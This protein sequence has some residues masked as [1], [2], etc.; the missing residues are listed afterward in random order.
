[1]MASNISWKD[2]TFSQVLTSINKNKN[3]TII[4]RRNMH[5]A[6]PLKIYRKEI[7]ILTVPSK[8]SRLNVSISSI[9]TPNG[10][11]NSSSIPINASTTTLDAKL[12]VGSTECPCLDNSVIFTP[13][14]NARR[15]VRTSGIIKQS[16]SL[17][18]KQYLQRRNISFEQNTY[19]FLRNGDSTSKPGT[20]ASS[21]NVYA[22]QSNFSTDCPSNHEVIYKPTN[23]K[24]A[25]DG[26]VSSSS[27]IARKKYIAITDNAHKYLK[28]FGAAV[29]DAMAYGISD[30]VYTYKSK[31]AFPTRITPISKKNTTTM[32]FCSNFTSR[33]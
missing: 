18:T 33:R 14:E 23:A 29:A 9:D 24:F 31:I 10:Y 27:L 26:A 17:D 13:Q 21:S 15:R 19:H 3:G 1:M 6:P 22:T 25:Q 28:P 32:H 16:Y 8:S 5:N 11:T 7:P 4:S 30:S 12:L 20:L 2:K